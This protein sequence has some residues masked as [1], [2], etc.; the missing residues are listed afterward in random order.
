M[1]VAQS[2]ERSA[3]TPEVRGSNLVI[4][5]AFIDYLITVNYI[6]KTKIKKE[7]A[8]NGPF[9]KTKVLAETHPSCKMPKL[10]S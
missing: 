7:E 8:G 3:L 5:K 6:E 4:S 9:K 1:V 2:A 10:N